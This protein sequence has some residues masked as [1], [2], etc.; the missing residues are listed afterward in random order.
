MVGGIEA[1]KEF[2]DDE[3]AAEIGFEVDAI[4]LVTIGMDVMVAFVPN[5]FVLF[6][7]EVSK[8]PAVVVGRIGAFNFPTELKLVRRI[9]R[10]EVEGDN[11]PRV[12]SD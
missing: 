11:I 2:T 12:R 10:V 7:E 6:E 9:E 4:L 1:F 5:S 3:L 8:G